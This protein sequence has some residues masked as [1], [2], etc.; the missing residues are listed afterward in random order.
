M[1]IMIV[2]PHILFRV[3]LISLLQEQPDIEIIGSGNLEPQVIEQISNSEPDV[4]IMGGELYENGGR[5]TV[6]EILNVYPNIA[7]MILA[8]RENPELMLDAIRNGARGYLPMDFSKSM[9]IKSLYAMA[10]GEVAISRSM[11]TKVA[12]EF[13]RLTRVI[14]DNIMDLEALTFREQQVLRLLAMDIT[15][16]EITLKLFIT[17][18]TVQI[19]VSGLP[20]KTNLVKRPQLEENIQ[21]ILPE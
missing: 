2:D 11:T 19:H 21:R 15:N 1:K 16:N 5:E 10:R 12:E 9:L 8:F 13:S 7:V 20:H 18:K 14:H 6:T 3:G 17:S 4:I